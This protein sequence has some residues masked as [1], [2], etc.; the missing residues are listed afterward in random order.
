MAT[1]LVYVKRGT[2]ITFKASG[3]TY[4]FMG[5]DVSNNNG[6]LSAQADLGAGSK[7]LEF[8]VKFVCKWVTAAPTIGNLV[9]LFLVLADGTG[10]EDIAGNEPGVSDAALSSIDKTKNWEPL[11]PLVVE[12]TSLTTQQVRIFRVT[13]P[14]RYF[15]LAIWNESGGTVDGD[16][17]APATYFTVTEYP[18]DIQ[19]AA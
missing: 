19:A 6:R 16:D 18:P 8:Y 9:K 3:G 17:G 11:E 1:N 7:P 14:T 5:A 10:A 2:P 4:V 13:I 15:S 12:S